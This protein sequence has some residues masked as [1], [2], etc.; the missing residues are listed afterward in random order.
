MWGYW[1]QKWNQ[2]LS[3]AGSVIDIWDAAVDSKLYFTSNYHMTGDGYH[4][5]RPHGGGSEY[6]SG[7]WV[8]AD[9][10]HGLPPEE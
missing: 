8:D 9:A 3:T 2:G 7:E 4:G 5:H 6:E 1:A 10:D